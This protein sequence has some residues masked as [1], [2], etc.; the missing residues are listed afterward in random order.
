MIES[1]DYLKQ[2]FRVKTINMWFND[3]QHRI[4]AKNGEGDA[5]ILAV[6][7]K[8]NVHQDKEELVHKISIV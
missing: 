2:H 5:T 4:D 3:L 8:V 7:K 6:K 1:C